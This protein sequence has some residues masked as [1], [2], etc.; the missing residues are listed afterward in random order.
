MTKNTSARV[1][2]P[3]AESRFGFYSML[4]TSALITF[5]ILFAAGYF[6][7][8]M[9]D[10]SLKYSENTQRTLT[11]LI[12]S[13]YARDWRVNNFES[14]EHIINNLRQNNVVKYVYV[15]SKKNR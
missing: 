11:T 6:L 12:T 13:T 14:S 15:V 10:L 1:H 3:I 2:K 8:Y 7:F 9:K 5:I 4:F